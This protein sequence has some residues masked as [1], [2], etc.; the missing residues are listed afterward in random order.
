MSIENGL[1]VNKD[2]ADAVRGM[3]KRPDLQQAHKKAM[4][5]GDRA[6]AEQI[7]EEASLAG[8]HILA[9]IYAAELLAHDPTALDQHITSSPTESSCS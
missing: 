6:K 2:S 8:Q 1:L 4:S 3:S 7:L 5:S 9:V